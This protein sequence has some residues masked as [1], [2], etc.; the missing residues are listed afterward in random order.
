M[1]KNRIFIKICLWF[2]VTTIIVFETVMF[3]ERL[4]QTDPRVKGMR[5]TLERTLPFYGQMAVDIYE[6]DG[7]SELIQYLVRLERATGIRVELYIASRP[8]IANERGTLDFAE[9]MAR[10]EKSGRVE[11]APFHGYDVAALRIAG[12]GGKTYTLAAE[13]RLGPPGRPG[14]PGGPPPFS[15]PKTLLHVILSGV[16]C[17]LLARH[18]TRPIVN[19]REATRRIAAGDLSVRI[20]ASMA[21]R[22]DELSDLANDFDVMAIRLE[23]L[24]N[25]QRNLLRDISHELRSPLARLNVALELCRRKLGSEAMQPLARIERESDRLEEMIGQLLALNVMESGLSE[26]ERSMIDLEDLVREI[27]GDALFEAEGK[28]R[29]VVLDVQSGGY[30]HGNRELLHRAIENVVRNAVR[31]TK[32]GTA[33]ELSLAVDHEQARIRVRDYGEGVP[34]ASLSKLFKPFYRVAEDRNRQ[35]G[36]VGLGLAISETAVR[37]H[38]GEIRAENAPNGGLIVEMI[39]PLVQRPVHSIK[40]DTGILP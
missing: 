18:L 32:E 33:V 29:S 11:F 19:L 22:R 23:E 25:S 34:V 16:I 27:A 38:H 36:G 5:H 10:A 15:L 6:R 24:L 17:Y 30:I 37:F 2:W 7:Q 13:A 3:V 26:A 40:N 9:V 20:G 4:T 12:P 14:G 21:R 8:L 35:T 39:L 31:Y 1:L 28:G